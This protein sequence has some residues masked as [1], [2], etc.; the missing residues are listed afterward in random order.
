MRSAAARI[1]R[2]LASD[3]ERVDTGLLPPSSLVAGA[4][5]SA[6]MGTAERDSEFVAGLAAQ[7]RRLHVPKM[8]RVRWLAA[9]DEACLLGGVAQ[10][11][12]VAVSAW[13]GNREDTLVDAS[14]QIT[15]G[16]R[17]AP[18]VPRLRRGGRGEGGRRTS[19]FASNF[20]RCNCS[21]IRKIP[22]APPLQPR[23]NPA[24]LPQLGRQGPAHDQRSRLRAP[25]LQRNLR[26]PHPR[27]IEL[28]LRDFASRLEGEGVAAVA[29][30]FA[31]APLE[32]RRH[33]DARRLSSGH[34]G[35]RCC[36][37]GVYPRAFARVAPIGGNL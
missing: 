31:G 8:V 7:R 1:S 25:A 16:A 35:R 27:K 37:P 28:G 20:F 30:D 33:W 34:G 10:M 23:A 11:L 15:S 9:A 17:D 14:G 36:S 5:Y 4:I 2:K 12:A 24:R 22:R 19:S 21:T 6:V 18:L 26:P 3:L 32:L 13:C 29:G